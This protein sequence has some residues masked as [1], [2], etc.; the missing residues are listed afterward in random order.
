VFSFVD[1]F[2]S[3]CVKSDCDH[4]HHRGVA[5]EVGTRAAI[6][7]P[8]RAGYLDLAAHVCQS[9]SKT[10]PADALSRSSMGKTGINRLNMLVRIARNANASDDYSGARK[11]LC[12]LCFSNSTLTSSQALPCSFTA[13]FKFSPLT[14]SASISLRLRPRHLIDVQ[15]RLCQLSC[16]SF[17]PSLKL[18]SWD[19]LGKPVLT[20]FSGRT[21]D[22]SMPTAIP[23]RF[24][25]AQCLWNIIAPAIALSPRIAKAS[26]RTDSKSNSRRST[27]SGHKRDDNEDH[28]DY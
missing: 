10:D 24:S 8:L 4:H 23:K 7:R 16:V 20:G 1:S 15:G 22:P 26:Q 12:P 14:R 19:L 18:H 28:G 3:W 25:S 5:P 2:D 27:S 21:V 17:L 9:S 11:G 13:F 6:D